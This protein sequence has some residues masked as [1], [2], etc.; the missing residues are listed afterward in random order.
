MVKESIIGIITTHQA[1]LRCFMK[2]FLNPGPGPGSGRGEKKPIHRFKNGAIV[3]VSIKSGKR[4]AVDLVYDGDIDEEKKDYVYYVSDPSLD[5]VTPIEH[6]SKKYQIIGFPSGAEAGS[7]IGTGTGVGT[8]DEGEGK[9]Y[10]FYLIRHGQAEHN[11]RKGFSKMFSNEDTNLTDKG[12]EQAGD[13]GDHLYKILSPSLADPEY[14]LRHL[15]LF[16]SDL[17]RTHQTMAVLMNVFLSNLIKDTKE[18]I[19]IPDDAIPRKIT[20]LACAHEVDLNGCDSP[21]LLIPTPSENVMSCEM[22]KLTSMLEKLKDRGCLSVGPE[23]G[24]KFKIDWNDYLDFYGGKTRRSASA[25]AL[26]KCLHTNFIDEAISII[27]GGR[28]VGGGRWRKRGVS[29]TRRKINR[30]I[31]RR[32]SKKQARARA[33][34]RKH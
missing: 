32:H 17:R 33:S 21:R 24:Y 26:R 16:A 5:K 3:K 28:A 6:E 4:A 1:R 19:S 34:T 11:I 2:S 13:I 22:D 7:G 15:Y 20:V 29:I 14:F 27:D 25:S 8:G 12:I 9:E 30:K 31:N 18:K 23:E 10:T